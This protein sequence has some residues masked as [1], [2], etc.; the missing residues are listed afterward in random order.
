MTVDHLTNSRDSK[1]SKLASC[2][3]FN[4]D[5]PAVEPHNTPS[6]KTLP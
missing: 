5:Q 2:R 1:V 4:L 6:P 3:L